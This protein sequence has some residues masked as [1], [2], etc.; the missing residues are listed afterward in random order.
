MRALPAMK[1]PCAHLAQVRPVAPVDDRICEDCVRLGTRWHHLRVCRACGH[2]GC[3]DQSPE[4]HARG[5]FRLTGHA[6]MRTTE[7]GEDWTWCFICERTYRDAPAGG[8]DP[9]DLFVEAGLPFARAHLDAGGAL[10][11]EPD[12]RS[13]EGFPL[14]DWARHVN[15]RRRADA[16]PPADEVAIAA[17][18][19]WTWDEVSDRT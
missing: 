3:C 18:S 14:G 10:P 11:F 2:K 12:A 9:V 4:R 16:L 5:H 17:L 6:I 19:G 15:E 8:F 7:P 13:P 1:A